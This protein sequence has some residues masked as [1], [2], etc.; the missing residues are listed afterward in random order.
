[1]PLF[2]KILVPLDGSEHSVHAL[3]KAVQIAKKFEGQ[4]TL[5]HAYSLT[6]PVSVSPISMTETGAVTPELMSTLAD[7]AHAHGTRILRNGEKKVQAEGVQVETLLREGHTVEEILKTAEEGK[8]DL[9]VM[10]A[11]GL[12]RIKEIFLG[13]VSHGVTTHARC[14]V[15][16]VK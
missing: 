12:S 3:K 6:L 8:F 10:G 13:S 11:R 1:M 14:P 2:Q 7:A 5:I 9:I 4:I 15:L 16:V